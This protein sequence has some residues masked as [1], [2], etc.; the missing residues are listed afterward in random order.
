MLMPMVEFEP[1]LSLPRFALKRKHPSDF[2]AFHPCCPDLTSAFGYNAPFASS[3]KQPTTYQAFLPC[4]QTLAIEGI[5][6]EPIPI[7]ELI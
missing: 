5:R 2:S 4:F 3:L 7:R 6:L 1:A